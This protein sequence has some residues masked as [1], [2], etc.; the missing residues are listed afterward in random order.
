M[1]NEGHIDIA[2]ATLRGVSVTR[3]AVAR[4]DGGRTFV[5]TVGLGWPRLWSFATDAIVTGF[6]N[7][8]AGAGSARGAA[9]LRAAVKGARDRFIERCEALIERQLPDA[10]VIGLALDGGELHV[11]A[12]GPV[13]AYLHRKG[14]S[15]RIS[16]RDEA[17]RGILDAP[18]AESSMW[19][20]PGDL[21]IAGSVSAFSTNAVARVASVLKQDP[22]TAPNVIAT[23]LTEPAEE[24]G[25]GAAS[26]VV[27]IS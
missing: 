1:R 13:R 8:L 14:E 7:G 5:A 18:I 27:R 11:H 12:V 25:V 16:P 17:D 9:R 20:D 24:A 2:K 22:G 21:V 19:L 3:H 4:F 10:A 23:L 15:Q 6:G 26:I